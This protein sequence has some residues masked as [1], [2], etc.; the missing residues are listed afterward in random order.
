[1]QFAAAAYFPAGFISGRTQTHGHVALQFTFQ[2][3]TNLAARHEL[4]LTAC[5]R[6]GVHHE[7][8]RERRFVHGEHRQCFGMSRIGDGGAD[9]EFFNAVHENDVTSLSAVD[10]LLVQAFELHDLI[11]L[12]GLG[13]VVRTIHDHD[14]LTCLERTAVHA[15]D[16]DLTHVARIVERADLKLQ[17][18]FSVVFT[19]RD[20]LDHGVEHSTHVADLLQ[21]LDIVGET[22][23]AVQGGSVDHRE[24]KLIFRS[25]EL[26]E[27]IKR[28][29]DNPVRTS[30]RA[31]NLVDHNDGF[32]TGGQSLAGYKARLRHRTFDSVNQQQYAVDHRQ[33][34]FDL[35][36]EVR[37]PRG[38]DDVNVNAF[39]LNSTVLGQ[40]CDAALLF[41]RVAVHHAFVN[42]L[43]AAKSACALQK[44]VDHGR[45][46]V[47]NVRND[48]NVANSSGHFLLFPVLF[49]VF[50]Y[51][52]SNQAMR[53]QSAS[54]IHLHRSQ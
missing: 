15:A 21:F 28:S 8:H 24:I 2:A 37:V 23:V 1:M 22:R 46:A 7:A 17:R 49:E 19:N 42:L 40:N 14:A 31:I 36:A 25:T 18:C 16:T 20:I 45:L 53:V 38:I 48:G 52:K 44:L 29:V 39:V 30:T 12:G 54:G 13:R 11:D 43:V 27:Q 32:Q 47:V 41:K 5:Q 26:V 35:T 4:A 10:D 3:F 34:A 9:V 6:R 51:Y 33:N 50:R